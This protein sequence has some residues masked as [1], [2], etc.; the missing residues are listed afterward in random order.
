MANDLLTLLV[1]L[2]GLG[3]FAMLLQVLVQAGVMTW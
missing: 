3:A 2:L 1:A